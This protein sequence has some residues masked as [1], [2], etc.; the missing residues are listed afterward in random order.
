MRVSPQAQAT[1][2]L[3]L[4]LGRAGPGDARP[5]SGKEWARLATWLDD[6]G[7]EPGSL[8]EGDVPSLLA[9]WID[10]S[11]S[12]ARVEALLH[13][14]A[15]LGLALE[16]WQ[17]AGLWVITRTDPD[18]PERLER[19]L[20]LG[21]P[22]V[23]VG[24]GSKHLLARG[25]IAV[26]GSRDASGEDLEFTEELGRQAARQGYSIVSGGARGIDRSAMLGALESE[27]TA[28]GV[29]ADSLLRAATSSAYRRRIMD[30]DLAL[31]TPFNPEAGFNVGNAMS[32]NRYI[33]CLA[34]AAVVVSCT[35]D[36][37]GTWAGAIEDLDA[38]WVPLWVKANPDP[39]SGNAELVRRGAHPIPSRLDSLAILLNGSMSDARAEEGSELPFAT[40]REERATYVPPTEPPENNP[41]TEAVP[42][43]L[44]PSN[45]LMKVG[46]PGVALDLYSFFVARLQEMTASEPMTAETIARRLELERAQV[47]AWLKRG[48]EEERIKRLPRPVRYQSMRQAS[49][50][51]RTTR[52]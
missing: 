30:G 15:A 4:S 8:L 2:L 7:R 23:L 19:H 10:R 21:A 37:G 20:R 49:L 27:G 50:F 18:Y 17:R 52:S 47:N 32:R 1:M 35:P 46:D 25:G 11:V 51:D 24:C 9:G 16:K 26:V 45:D 3:T 36:K 42:I 39:R 6:H 41:S 31:V 12:A 48:I 14:G 28:V 22:P 43:E 40:L 44:R 29:L 5:L 33:Y 13:R 38:R 34:D